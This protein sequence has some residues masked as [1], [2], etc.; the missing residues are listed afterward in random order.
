[1][2]AEGAEIFAARDN[3]VDVL[4]EPSINSRTI[5]ARDGSANCAVISTSGECSSTLQY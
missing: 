1:M 4:E 3:S 2:L 5:A